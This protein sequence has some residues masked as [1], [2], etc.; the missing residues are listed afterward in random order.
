MLALVLILIM[1]DSFIGIACAQA[2]AISMLFEFILFTLTGA[3]VYRFVA[4]PLRPSLPGAHVELA[5]TP[6]T[7]ARRRGTV[8]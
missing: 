1:L 3:I 5:A 2:L 6:A 7:L 8:A 4:L